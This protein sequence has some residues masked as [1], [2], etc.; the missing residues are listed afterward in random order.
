MSY[1]HFILKVYLVFIEKSYSHR[2]SVEG[3]SDVPH[4]NSL[5]TTGTPL[6]GSTI[7]KVSGPE[8]ST[9]MTH[10]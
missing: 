5:D 3:R 10:D 6:V 8:I 4:V 1:G 2:V 9:N 7:P